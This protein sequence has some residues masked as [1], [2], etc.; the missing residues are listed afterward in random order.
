MIPVGLLNILGKVIAEQQIAFDHQLRI[1]GMPGFRKPLMV[2]D[3][4]GKVKGVPNRFRCRF[5][6]RCHHATPLR[7]DSC[8]EKRGQPVQ[9]ISGVRAVALAALFCLVQP[10]F[11]MVSRAASKSFSA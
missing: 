3:Q 8:E 1:V 9:E 11:R 2:Q 4:F 10:I 5:D 6:F 7:G